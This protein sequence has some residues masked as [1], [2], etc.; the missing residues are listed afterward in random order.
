[1]NNSQFSY[2]EITP[3]DTETN[4]HYSNVSLNE[5]PSINVNQIMFKYVLIDRTNSP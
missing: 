2:S 1:M 5:Y 4:S 3:I